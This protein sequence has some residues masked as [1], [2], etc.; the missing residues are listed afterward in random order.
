MKKNIWKIPM[1]GFAVLTAVCVT[2]IP[3]TGY[4]APMIN[5]AL[6]AETQKIVKDPNAQIFYWT[7]YDSEEVA[8]DWNVCRQVMAEG[9]SVLLNRDG[10]LPLAPDSKISCFSQS[11]VDPV[12]VGTG[13]AF[14]ST[15]EGASL[16][17]ALEDSFQPGCV[18]TDLWKFY[19]TSGYKRENAAL[20]GGDPSQY[21]INEVPWDK[22]T[23]ALKSTFAS[24]GDAALVVLSRS[25][26]E[27]ADLPSGLTEL[28][29]YMTDGDYLRLCKEEMDLLENLKAVGSLF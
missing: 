19:V 5:V 22:Y 12:K 14:V 18:N 4:F 26:G 15:G 3:I 13:S 9:A 27:G 10:A 7:N 20:S 25:S 2:A 11:S 23:D 8:N 16:Y 6:N 21:R 24:Y 17:S 29:P 28:E 1:A